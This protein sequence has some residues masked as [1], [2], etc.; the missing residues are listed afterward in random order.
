MFAEVEFSIKTLKPI[1]TGRTAAKSRKSIFFT[2]K[3]YNLIFNY[4]NQVDFCDVM[5]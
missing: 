1:I 2:P 3:N 4:I 5:T